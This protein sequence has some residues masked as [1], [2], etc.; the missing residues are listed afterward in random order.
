MPGQQDLTTI[1]GHAFIVSDALG[2]IAAG[3]DQGLFVAD[4]RFLSRYT[5]RLAGQEPILLRSGPVGPA[6]TH[7]YATNAAFDGHPAHTLELIRCRR[8]DQAF[9]ETISLTNRGLKPVEIEVALT[10]DADFADIFEVR[11]LMTARPPRRSIGRTE[12]QQI[13]FTDRRRGRDRMAQISFSQ[14]PGSVARGT[15]RFRV[16]LSPAETWTV[17]VRVAWAVPEVQT[18]DPIPIAGIA[19]EEPLATWLQRV[20][21]LTTDDHDLELAYD[22]AVRDLAALE[23][24]L[25]SGHAIPAAGVPWYLAIFGRDALITS[26]QSL[27]LGPRLALGTLRTLAAYQ[28]TERSDFRDSEP[29]KMPHEIRFGELAGAG[30]VPH[31]RY[32]GTVDA[33]PLWILLLAEVY[34][35]TEDRAILDELLPAAERAL[36]WID[37]HGDL[38]GDG[39]IE[40]E[41]RSRRGLENQNWKDS[42]DSMRFADGRFAEPPIAAVE[43]QGYVYAAKQALADIY[44]VRARPADAARLRTEAARLKHLVHEAFWLPDEEFYALALDHDKRPV[45]SVTSNPGHLLWSGL[46]E[47]P[48]AGKVVERLMAPDCFSGWGIRTMASTMVAYSPISY[49]NGSIWPHDNS[50]IIAGFRR[51]GYGREAVEVSNGLIAAARWF[52]EHRLPELFCGYDREQTPFPVDYPVACSPQAWA[53]GSVPLL[54]QELAG[55]SPKSDGLRVNP[56]PH[57]RTFRLTGVPFR[58]ERH[59]VVADALVESESSEGSLVHAPPVD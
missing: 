34:R 15:A 28:A 49:H 18:I 17:D 22:R 30:T 12:D 13:A 26:F 51:Y 10:F 58:G 14:P 20:P 37:E 32:Y 31:S 55:I 42:W 47:E 23:L 45:D 39:L 24:A 46:P 57:G 36:G 33:T 8:L 3:A 53:A 43:V 59:E 40:Y 54:L 6:E 56:L 16:H 19:L 21:R 52:D 9:V 50:L 44:D 38:D 2:D 41:R 5:L 4:T 48:Y 35:W 1:A 11:A 29:G 25:S 7:V 27:L